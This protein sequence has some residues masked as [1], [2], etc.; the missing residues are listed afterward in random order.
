MKVG[1]L[2]TWRVGDLVTW[3]Y[4]TK[5]NSIE[6][7]YGVIVERFGSKTNTNQHYWVSFINGKHSHKKKI[8]CKENHLIL[9]RDMKR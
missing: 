2:V 7:E 4:A 3:R 8:L 9:V 1:D 5:E 6:V